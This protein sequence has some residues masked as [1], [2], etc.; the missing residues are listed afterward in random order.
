MPPPVELEKSCWTSSLLL[1]VSD[2]ITRLDLGFVSVG[3]GAGS[4]EL[5]FG[6]G[7]GDGAGA[8][9]G[10]D[11]FVFGFVFVFVFILF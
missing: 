7:D 3:D 10:S 2:L 11:D 5:V 8:G 4:D 1:D 6:A 9:A